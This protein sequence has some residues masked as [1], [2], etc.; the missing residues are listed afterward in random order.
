MHTT[1][2]LNMADEI[3]V[4]TERMDNELSLILANAS[5]LAAAIPKGYPGDCYFCGE[6]FSRVVKVIDPR[7]DNYV[8]S[9][10]RCRDARGIA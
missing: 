5:R 6:S 9:C 8:D 3:D 4:T 1:K 7:T 2:K 10:G